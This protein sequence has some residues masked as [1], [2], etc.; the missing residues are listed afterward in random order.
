[1][2]KVQI[3]VLLTL[4][5]LFYACKNTNS[6]ENQQNTPQ[7][8]TDT[9]AQAKLGMK[10]QTLYAWV[11]KLRLRSAPTTKAKVVAEVKEGAALKYLNEKTAFTQKIIL[12]KIQHDEPWLKV[13]TEDG[14]EG[15]VYGGGVR[16]YQA[17]IDHAPSP[18]DACYEIADSYKMSECIN[19]LKPKELKKVQRYI[20]ATDSGYEIT[21]LDGQKKILTN[22][23]DSLAREDYMSY[24]YRYYI[25]K[26]GYFVFEY[27]AFESFGYALVN[28]KSGKIINIAGYPK[29]APDFKHLVSFNPI[30]NMGAYD[31][32][33]WGFTEDGLTSLFAKEM[34]DYV[35]RSPKWLDAQTVQVTLKP[36]DTSN[37]IKVIEL[38]ADEKGEWR[39]YEK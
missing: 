5:C 9:L 14:K 12:R 36:I 38:S 33:I 1:M 35:P 13:A 22:R 24:D 39:L 26:M 23:M 34:Y 20:Q 6:S 7:N 2:A 3:I 25:S 37:E 31:L 30:P 21:L 29:P 11:D 19:Q 28:D 17:K 8:S 4:F 10:A 32:Q 27:Y 16:V 15:W 18:Y